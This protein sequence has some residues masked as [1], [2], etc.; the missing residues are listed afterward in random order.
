MLAFSGGVK[1][2]A[3]L[4]SAAMLVARI[5]DKQKTQVGSQRTWAAFL[6][7]TIAGAIFFVQFLCIGGWTKAARHTLYGVVQGEYE[8]HSCCSRKN[9][10]K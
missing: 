9:L 2:A 1:A 5:A 7:D 6:P 3:H 8:E 4:C 10:S